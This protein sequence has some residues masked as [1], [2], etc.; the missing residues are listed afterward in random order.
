MNAP[1]DALRRAGLIAVAGA[2]GAAVIAAGA[3]LAGRTRPQSPTPVADLP[4]A[5]AEQASGQTAYRCRCGAEYRVSGTDRHRVFW[6]AD[7][8]EDEPVLGDDCVECGEPLPS[9][10]AMP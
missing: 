8:P 5:Q 1:S 10:R 3:R 2:A 9:G 4:P 7:A 6:P